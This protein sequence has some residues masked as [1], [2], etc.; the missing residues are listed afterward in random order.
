[1]LNE[2]RDLAEMTSCRPRV[3]V[4]ADP[5]DNFLLSMA[6]SVRADYLITGDGRHVLKLG[7]YGRTR[8][9]SVRNGREL[10]GWAGTD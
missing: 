3:D 2:I 1:M 5:A 8:I 9:I 10:F 7:R 6:V 4:S